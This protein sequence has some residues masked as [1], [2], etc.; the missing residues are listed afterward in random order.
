MAKAD[1]IL[2]LFQLHPF[3]LPFMDTHF[4]MPDP[5][6]QIF[7]ISFSVDPLSLEMS[8]VNLMGCH[9]INSVYLC[10]QHG[11]LKQ[12]STCMGSLY[13]QDFSGAMNLWEM[14]IV[15][16]SLTFLQ[17]QINWYFVHSPQAFTSYITC[18]NTSSSN[19]FVKSG[20]NQIFVSPSS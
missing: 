7:L 14:E 13:M 20:T 4:L 17:L 16:Q 6:N 8:A 11:V 3:P 5:A 1:S 9:S 15:M 2:C 10:K 19:I 18:L 12:N